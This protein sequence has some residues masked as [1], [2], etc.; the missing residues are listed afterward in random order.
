MP[1]K[2]K[3]KNAPLTKDSTYCYVGD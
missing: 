3:Q 2:G 1:I